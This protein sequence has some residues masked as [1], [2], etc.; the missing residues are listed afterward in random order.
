MPAPARYVPAVLPGGDVPLARALAFLSLVQE[1][2]Q[3]ALVSSIDEAVREAPKGPQPST[4]ADHVAAFEAAQP[5]LTGFALFEAVVT[6]TDADGQPWA[7]R[8][9]AVMVWRVPAGGTPES[10]SV[11]EASGEMFPSAAFAEAWSFF[12]EASSTLTNGLLGLP[13]ASA[14]SSTTPET[15]ETPG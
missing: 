10:V 9:A 2:T 13:P 6:G 3:A 7:P 4:V 15:A 1:V 14:L 5:Q 11:E 8:F 12:F